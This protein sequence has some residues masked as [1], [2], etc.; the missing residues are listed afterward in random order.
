MNEPDTQE[1]ERVAEAY[2]NLL[3]PALFAEWT[4]RLS[5]AVEIQE[6]QH[7]LDVACGTGILA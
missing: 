5:D 3:A 6:G 4:H 2:E 7:V 1:L